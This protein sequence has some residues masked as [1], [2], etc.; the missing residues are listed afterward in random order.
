VYGAIVGIE[1]QRMQFSDFMPTV[2]SGKCLARRHRD[3]IRWG[4]GFKKLCE[5]RGANLGGKGGGD[6]KKH[7]ATVAGCAKEVGV[8]E[9]TAFRRIAQANT[10][11]A[12][13]KKQQ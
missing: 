8:T 5:E 9:R 3:G 7:S 13:P 12:L 11:E 4:K 10:Y 2:S 6:P 1:A